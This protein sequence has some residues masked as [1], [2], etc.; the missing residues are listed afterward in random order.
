ML[1][2]RLRRWPNI[3]P[4]LGKRILYAGIYSVL[5]L[6]VQWQT[7]VTAHLNREQLPLSAE[8]EGIMS[9]LHLSKHETDVAEG[10]TTLKQPWVNVSPLAGMG[11]IDYVITLHHLSANQ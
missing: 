2:H 4:T 9:I 1:G 11:T 7:T 3:E 5:S 10:G 6:C 8:K